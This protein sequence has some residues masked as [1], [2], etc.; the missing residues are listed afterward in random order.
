M[1]LLVCRGYNYIM[2]A[3]ENNIA[4][5]GRAGRRYTLIGALAIMLA[6][7]CWS[8]DG[9]FIRPRFYMFPAELVVFWEH[10]LGLIV[11]S[12]FIFINWYKIKLLS[13]KSWEALIWISFFGGALGTIMITQAFFA[14]I[15]GQISFAAVI[16]LQKLQ[17]IFAL[18]LARIL[19]KE[20]LPKNFYVWAALAVAA[21]YFIAFGKSGLDL[22]GFDWRHSAAL[23]SF[24]A[25]FA[26]GS[27]TVYGK[28]ATNHLD[29]RAV[30]ALRFALTAV[31]VLV[32]ALITGAIWQTP[33]FTPFYWGLFALIVLT[34]GAGSMFIY[35]FGLRRVSASACTI[36]ELFWPF[37]AL[38]LDYVF[39]HNYLNLTQTIAFFVLLFAF[40]KV[41]ML[42]RLKTLTFTAKVIGGQGRGHKLGYPTA[43]L[44]KT[45][46]DIPHGVYIVAVRVKGRDYA[47]LMH[48]G[49][50]EAFGEPVSLEVLIKDFFEDIYSQELTV[51][52]GRKLREVKKFAGAEE[53]QA[54]I[55]DDLRALEGQ[56]AAGS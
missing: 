19:L 36:L 18:L 8:I 51:T 10:F 40:Y 5:S 32:Y 43:N 55:R 11:L 39:N 3:A 4:A 12:P 30:A 16:I 22:S 29:Y 25:A 53:L 37:S 41:Y 50:R 56:P 9:L 49:F 48:F 27:S 44:D 20:K 45:D 21:S 31:I 33:S 24:L 47:G 17:P 15:D 34:S 42:D 1:Y 7:L 35:Y 52:V 26:F 46:L 13:W 2:S 54:A 6:A 14:A 23:F 28:R 38:I